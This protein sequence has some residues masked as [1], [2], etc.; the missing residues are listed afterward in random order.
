MNQKPSI[1][2]AKFAAPQTAANRKG[3]VFVLATDDG[4]LSET[5]AA[6]DP[7]K[8]LERAFP[9]AE[10]T[11][12]FA[13]V[14]EVLTPQASSLDRLVA[15]GAGKVSGLDEYAWTKLG[16]TIAGSLRKATDVAVVL[17]VVGASSSGAQA[18]S[19]AAGIL[20][21][22]YSFDKYKTRKDKDDGEGDKAE[23]K[24]PAKITIHTA[25][26]A[27]A[28][29]AFAETEAVIDGVLLARDLVN[30]PANVLGPVE[31]AARAKEL[32]A[33]GVK[34][35]ILAE[36][37]MKKLGMGSLLGVAQGSP[38]GAR[39]AVMQWN[40]GKAKD[41]PV[42]FIGKGVTFDTGGNSMKPASGMEDMKGD[43]GGAAAVTGLMH[44]LAARKA[45]AN[46][47]G[48][49]GLVENAVDGHA[50]RPGDI[51]TSMS[52][53]TI[54][55]LNTDAEGRLVLA[56]AL[57]Y[58]N[59][60]FQ[61]KFM[62]NLATLTGAIMVALGQHYA[63]LFS[64]NDELAERLAT[65]GQST[66]ERLWRMPLG[67]E[68]DKLIDSKNADMKN[69]GGRYGGAI[70]AAQFLQ[71]FVKD[72]PWAHLDIAGTAMGALSNEINQSW[73]SGFGVRLLD[74]LVRDHYEN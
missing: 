39:M 38:R 15:V 64:N 45:K 57:W 33:L 71:R 24:K 56:D 10:F 67:P 46:V 68:Y 70:I 43:M 3:T 35:E 2:F 4:G 11:A 29:K 58:C 13:S 17:D 72:T 9:V 59:D 21:R 12:K 30:E 26:P 61:P 18:A 54:E 31:F 60:R 66:Q 19:L 69:I 27:G 5:A 42:A 8:T 25:D 49:I 73:G 55:V 28:K 63:G 53:Q 36:K 62:V 48:I 22:S 41:S 16:G 32:E 44:A 23:P 1:A 7:G 20:L 6:Y 52:G 40:G 34:V 65:A 74:R 51:V 47:V 37:E 50:Q 14:V